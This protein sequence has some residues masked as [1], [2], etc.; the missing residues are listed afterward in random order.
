MILEISAFELI[1]FLKV[2]N[3]NSIITNYILDLEEYYQYH[4]TVWGLV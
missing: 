1:I 3:L 2:E 4:I